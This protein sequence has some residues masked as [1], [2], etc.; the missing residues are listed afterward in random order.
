M[1]IQAAV[2]LFLHLLSSCGT[3]RSILQTSSVLLSISSATRS[4]L[5][6]ISGLFP[7]SSATR[8]IL[9]TNSIL[10]FNLFHITI[11]AQQHMLSSTKT[12]GTI[13]MP[14]M[15]TQCGK[16]PNGHGQADTKVSLWSLQ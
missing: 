12:S 10:L 9:Q 8:S 14:L 1:A 6:T 4:T 3:F 7:I 16:G 15:A 2:R 5:L 11:R 13:Q